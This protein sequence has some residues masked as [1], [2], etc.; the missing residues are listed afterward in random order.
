MVRHPRKKRRSAA[1]PGGK[2]SVK[3]KIGIPG[4]FEV[5]SARPRVG[6]GRATGTVSQSVGV[7]LESLWCAPCGVSGDPCKMW[8]LGMCLLFAHGALTLEPTTP[9]AAAASQGKK[10]LLPSVRS[11][12]SL[13]EISSSSLSLRCRHFDS[14]DLCFAVILF[15]FVF[16]IHKY[17][18]LCL[19]YGFLPIFRM[20]I[21]VL[22]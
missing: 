18:E 14:A 4:G 8:I 19:D 9:A 16:L 3:S 5:E 7:R 21:V 11:Y 1:A 20:I 22:L 10:P 2:K 12:R 6:R 13:C 17:F 15:N